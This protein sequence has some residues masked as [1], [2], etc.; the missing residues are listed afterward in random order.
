M[1]CPIVLICL[2]GLVSAE[3]SLADMVGGA[4]YGPRILTNMSYVA[5]LLAIVIAGM[6]TPLNKK[7]LT[8]FLVLLVAGV[9]IA[10]EG[11]YNPASVAWNGVP[12]S[13]GSAQDGA[14]WVWRYP[15]WDMTSRSLYKMCISVIRCVFLREER[16][17]FNVTCHRRHKSK[18]I[19]M[20]GLLLQ[21]SFISNPK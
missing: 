17:T 19:V 5:A 13:N 11:M 8:L 10:L 9:P 18:T 4:S 1:P 3:S 2:S 6:A 16:F 15:Q 14:V 12:A 20:L 21:G 7:V